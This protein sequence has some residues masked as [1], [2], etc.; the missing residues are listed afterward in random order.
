MKE[1]IGG[2]AKVVP[3]LLEHSAVSVSLAGWPAVAALAV[4]GVT[5]VTVTVVRGNNRSAQAV[6]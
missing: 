2:I 6:G 1:I 4:V 3:A 5:V